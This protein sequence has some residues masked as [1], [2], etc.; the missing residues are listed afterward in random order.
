MKEERIAWQI[1]QHLNQGIEDLDPEVVAKLRQARHNA[2]ARQRVSIRSGA[3]AGLG[4]INLTVAWPG[5]RAAMAVAGIAAG[6]FLVSAWNATMDLEDAD[7]N[8]ELDTALLADDLP[9]NAYLDKGFATWLVS[10]KAQ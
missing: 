7:A 5:L 10:D 3:L 4:N 6:V 8:G 2:L 9:L 1:K